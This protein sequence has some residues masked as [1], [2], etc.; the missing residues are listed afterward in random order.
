MFTS[1]G[2]TAFSVGNCGTFMLSEQISNNLTKLLLSTAEPM[3][4]KWFIFTKYS[5]R[6]GSEQKIKNKIFT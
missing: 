3:S 1:Y 6:F 5:S 4:N 2:K